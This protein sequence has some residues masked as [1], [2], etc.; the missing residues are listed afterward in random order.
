MKYNITYFTE[1]LIIH[2][3]KL[4]IGFGILFFSI[5]CGGAKSPDI[6]KKEDV[7]ANE[8]VFNNKKIAMLISNSKKNFEKKYKKSPSIII[9]EYFVK[10]SVPIFV[11]TNYSFLYSNDEDKEILNYNFI[12]G[13]VVDNT[14][15]LLISNGEKEYS[16]ELFR[17]NEVKKK[18]EINFGKNTDMCQQRFTYIGNE[19][20]SIEST[21]SFD[22]II[23]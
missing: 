14:T 18:F 13:N 10:D 1:A 12:G 16:S 4:F 9:M 15:I 8:L 2:I 5:S 23:E 7:I 17:V 22:L 6:T 20:N 19:F 11:V 21:C 3:K